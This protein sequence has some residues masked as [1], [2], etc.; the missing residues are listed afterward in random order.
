MCVLFQAKVFEA[1]EEPLP[2]FR[3]QIDPG[4]RAAFHT[5]GLDFLGPFVPFGTDDKKKVWIVIASCTLTRAM[6]L[7]TVQGMHLA[8]LCH[9]FNTICFNYNLQPV[10]IVSDRAETFRA[11]YH[12]LLWLHWE[13]SNK[14]AYKQGGPAVEWHFNASRAPWWGGFF[15]HMMRMIKGNKLA[16]L[17]T[18]HQGKHF[19]SLEA[20][21]EAV[22]WTQLV[23]NSRPIS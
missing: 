7:R 23:L 13:Q 20:F 5:M 15:E 14:S 10:R 18:L 4:R 16:R 8:M 2:D 22:A 1:P 6:I 17:F 12:R 11:A 19:P 3:F 9:R 21:Q